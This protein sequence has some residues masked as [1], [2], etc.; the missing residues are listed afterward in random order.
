MHSRIA[1]HGLAVCSGHFS[2]HPG[3]LAEVRAHADDPPP[4]QVRREHVREPGGEVRSGP[5]VHASPSQSEICVTFVPPRGSTRVGSTD[6]EASAR[7]HAS[8]TR[9]F[10]GARAHTHTSNDDT[11]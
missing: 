10:A 9:A 11:R 7:G 5:T 6:A 2:K 4:R 3:C 8:E 1:L